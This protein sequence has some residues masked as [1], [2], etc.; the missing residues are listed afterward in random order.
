VNIKVQEFKD[1]LFD[2]QLRI[3][4]RS[5]LHRQQKQLNTNEQP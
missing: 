1:E 4:Y 2:L 3:F 5:K